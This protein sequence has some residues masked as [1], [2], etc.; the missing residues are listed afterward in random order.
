[1]TPVGISERSAGQKGA[2]QGAARKEN[3]RA[4]E[5]IK[6]LIAQTLS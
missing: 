1:M 3:R 6:S 2:G 4:G 5:Q